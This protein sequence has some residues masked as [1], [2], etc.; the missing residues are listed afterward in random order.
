M[1]DRYAVVWTRTDTAPIKMGN[2]V[3]TDREMRFSYAPEFL[4]HRD[5]GG[6]S[7]LL[8]PA[9][10]QTRPFVHPSSEIL[11]L[12][13]RL[14]ALIPGKNNNNI[15]RRIHTSL[16]AKRPRPPAPGFETEWELLMM[17]GHN[18]I[19]H[20]DVFRDDREATAFYESKAE[21]KQRIGSRSTFWNFLK[22]ETNQELSN[23]ALD[24][25]RLIGPTP[26]VGG[27]I[28]KLLVA[29]PDKK[30]WD[31]TIAEP[32]TRDI[33]G[34]T[35]TDVVMK[36][37]DSQYRG[38]AALEALCL[39][40]HQELGFDVPRHWRASID[41]LAVL[42]I[43]RFDRT[44]NN[45]PIPMESFFSVYATGQQQV[46]TTTDAELEQVG[47]MLVKLSEIADIDPD[48]AGLEIYRRFVMALL[49]GNGDLHLENMAFLGGPHNIRIAPVFDPAP[50]RAWDRH[51]LLSALPFYIDDKQGLKLS[52]IKLGEAF[53]VNNKMAT[54]LL[55]SFIDSTKN[56]SERVLTLSEVPEETKK[57]LAAR[58]KA[59]RTRLAKE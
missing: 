18:G 16:L 14:M 10:W 46:R 58:V 36:V 32:G 50:M 56:Y 29:I 24:I 33:D 30:K 31:G 2:L 5:I 51:D 59:L 37:D 22:D 42:A 7:L 8:P 20:I 6:L 40:V 52:L 54:E 11:P 55:N 13:P 9:L 17:T 43:E 15:Q 21:P 1:T 57:K 27:Q 41:D 44:K 28:P 47:A 35:Y 39:D 26:S 25:V 53:G 49:T 4:E 3:A 34:V 45:L 38:L 23:E 19:G 48:K 12:L